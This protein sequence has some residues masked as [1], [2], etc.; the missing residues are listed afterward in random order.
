MASSRF[1]PEVVG[2]F[3]SGWNFLASSMY[4]LLICLSD[5]ISSRLKPK[6][7]SESLGFTPTPSGSNP[8]LLLRGGGREVSGFGYVA[9]GGDFSD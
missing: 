4:L 1:L 2:S 6:I 5:T 8:L 9:V 3:L 7:P